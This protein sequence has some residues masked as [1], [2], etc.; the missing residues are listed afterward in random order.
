MSSKK[1]LALLAVILII[2]MAATACQPA[3]ASETPAAEE[4]TGV[5]EPVD[6]GEETSGEITNAP[7]VRYSILADLTSTNVW[8]LYDLAGSSYWNYA[9]QGWQ[10]PTLYAVSD[11]RWDYIPSIADGFPSEVTQE[12]EFYVATVTLKE[13]PVWSDGT[14]VTA[15]DVVFTVTTAM[16]FGLGQNWNA[17]YNPDYLD[18]VE[19]VD[20][21][22]LRYY[23]SQTPG[24]PVWQYGALTGPIVNQAYWEPRIAD[25]VAQFQALDPDAEDFVDA[26]GVL[27]TNLEALPGG[28]LE[29]EPTSG[30]L[31]LS[32]WE[33][34][35]YAETTLD[36]FYFFRGSLIEE[37]AN[38]TYREVGAEGS[39]EF[40][41]YGEPSGEITMSYTNGPHFDSALY[42]LYELRYLCA[43]IAEQ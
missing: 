5:T 17:A 20:P 29:G 25:L 10:W 38:G 40:V 8:N 39:Y 34:G 33:V 15:N 7:V 21:M 9:V 22:T 6:A 19:A 23:F 36:P 41:A 18:H 35:A 2:G 1:L 12:G 26:S 43:G 28:P 14:P 13:G 16:L 11:V 30:G 31:R 37:Y 24:L 42:T 27:I 4:G 32:G 3:P